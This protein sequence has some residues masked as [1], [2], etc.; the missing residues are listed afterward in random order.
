MTSRPT[1][2]A[3]RDA[4]ARVLAAGRALA[5]GGAAL[6]VT[7]GALAAGVGLSVDEPGLVAFGL[8]VGLSAGAAAWFATRGARERVGV[9]PDVARRLEGVVSK[10]VGVGPS[11]RWEVAVGVGGERVAVPTH[12]LSYL[13]E[14]ERHTVWAVE[15]TGEPVA[16]AVEGGPSADADRAAG[17]DRVLDLGL[18][19]GAYLAVILGLAAGV[20]AAVLSVL[21]MG[22]PIVV[23]L[24][25]ALAV[26][27]AVVAY[28]DV[29]RRGAVHRAYYEAGTR[30]A[31]PPTARRSYR[32]RRAALYGL[33]GTV[34][35]ALGVL[36]GLNGAANPV[37]FVA[38]VAVASAAVAPLPVDEPPGDPD[39]P[40]ASVRPAV[41]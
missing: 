13:V 8:V 21:G 5:V 24:L 11:G 16:V 18:R 10:R 12:W 30:F 32:L 40:G 36:V 1:T 22:A 25:A 38:L 3:E 27:A 17:A 31:L 2:P 33:V 23:A 9:E 39:N 15:T 37:A 7:A 26:P 34:A 20:V 4:A 19:P 14:G 29:R 35:G 6:A 28:N 41:R